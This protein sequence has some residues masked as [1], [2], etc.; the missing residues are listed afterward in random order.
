MLGWSRQKLADKALVSL[1][2][3]RRFETGKVDTRPETTAKLRATLERAG[4]QFL[5]AAGSAEGIRLIPKRK[6]A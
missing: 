3:I 6:S 5:S 1:M 4:I 2:A